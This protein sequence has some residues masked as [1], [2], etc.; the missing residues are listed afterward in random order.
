MLKNYFFETKP[1][2]TVTAPNVYIGEK[3]IKKIIEETKRQ[4]KVETGGALIG[5][6]I[7][8][9]LESAEIGEPDIYILET[10]FPDNSAKRKLDSFTL[11]DNYQEKIF[12]QLAKSWDKK[13]ERKIIEK[14][15]DH[16]LKYLG[17]WHKHPAVLKTP[18]LGDFDT[19]RDMTRGNKEVEEILVVVATRDVENNIN[20]VWNEEEGLLEARLNE[21]ISISFS[22]LSETM[23]KNN[24]KS[25]IKIK[26]DVVSEFSDLLPSLPSL[27]WYLA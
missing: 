20:C 2:K 19:A 6:K 21:K 22:Y 5:I 3:T 14:K 16:P 13:R 23:L 7:P 25:F 24:Y 1:L 11:G 12:L 15:F 4:F 9:I 8:Q 27:P 18:S 10:I 17:D 26:P